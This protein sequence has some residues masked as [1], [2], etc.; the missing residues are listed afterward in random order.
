VAV[1]FEE[2]MVYSEG[3]EEAHGKIQQGHEE[4]IEKTDRALIFTFYNSFSICG[5]YN[6]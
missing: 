4:I 5:I 1:E 2:E 6:Y 3:W